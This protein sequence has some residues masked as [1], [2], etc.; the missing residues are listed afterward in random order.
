MRALATYRSKRDFTRSREPRGTRRIAAAASLR[1]VIQK[2]AARRLHYDLRLELDG[3][4]KSWALTKGPSLDPRQ[5]R[6]AVEVEDHPLDYGDFEG[7]IPAGEYGGGTVQLWDRGW[8]H[9][10]PGA[11]P[12]ERLRAGRLK[13]DLQGKRLTG[14]WALVRM[15]SGRTHGKRTSWL[16]IKHRDAA[17]RADRADAL[18][19]EDRSIASGR[20]MAQIAAGKGRN[21][22]PFMTARAKTARGPR[23]RPSAQSRGKP[24]SKSRKGSTMPTFI[25][26]QLAQLVTRPP[27]GRGWGHEVKLDGYRMQLRVSRG[28]AKLR[29]RKGLDWTERFPHIQE[30]AAALPDCML[31]GEVVALD[32]HGASSFA[33]LQGA[34]SNGRDAALIYYAFDLIFLEGADLRRLALRDRKARLKSLLRRTGGVDAIRYVE[35]VETAGAAVL[36]S[37][38]RAALEGIVS[39]RLDG[40]YHSGRDRDWCKS[41]CRAGQEVIIGGWTTQQGQVR[42]LLVGVRR[43][44]ELRYVGRVGT[45]F[46]R[47]AVRQ[48]LPRLRALAVKRSPFEGPGAPRPAADIRWVKPQLVAEIEFAGWTGDGNVRQAAFKALREDKP[49]GEITKEDPAIVPRRGDV[50]ARGRRPSYFSDVSS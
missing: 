9:P 14:Q 27:E 33:A 50:P 30:A 16:L 36:E 28:E 42:S 26:P 21:P 37:A 40:P 41:K 45:G 8:W 34:F 49:A 11:D 39:K 24:Q 17:A 46:G 3:V 48:L 19:D 6:L 31:D 13:F 10:E 15:S 18:L 2:H 32:E 1:F 20:T 35:H 38:C 22:T 5:R 47:A 4:F 23:T 29:T 44:G 12:E 7:T 25:P 43:N